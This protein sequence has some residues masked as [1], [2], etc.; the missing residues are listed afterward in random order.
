MPELPEMETIRAGLA[1]LLPVT[2]ITFLVGALALCAI[3]PFSGF[4]SKDSIIEAVKASTLPFH[5]FAYIA[6]LIGVFVTAFYTGVR[7]S[8]CG[9]A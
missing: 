5:Y 6:V 4:Y 2:Y 1:Q 8:R 3:P 9:H 7:G